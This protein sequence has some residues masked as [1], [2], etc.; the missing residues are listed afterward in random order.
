MG[1]LPVICFT[2]VY[3]FWVHGKWLS[4]LDSRSSTYRYN[5]TSSCLD[6]YLAYLTYGSFWFQL[7]GFSSNLTGSSG[8]ESSSK[9]AT[10]S[11]NRIASPHSTTL[12]PTPRR[13]RLTTVGGWC[14]STTQPFLSRLSSRRF[15]FHAFLWPQKR[16][17]GETWYF[18]PKTSN[19]HTTK[20]APLGHL[21][22]S[23][24]RST[25]TVRAHI[26]TEQT[27]TVTLSVRGHLDGRSARGLQG[28]PG[29][30]RPYVLYQAYGTKDK[31]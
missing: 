19:E 29:K 12:A 31:N 22:P 23:I 6:I 21:K 2:I 11:H 24:P 27:T 7:S 26:P 14:D 20:T 15:C 10:S 17:D 4:R 13:Q 1:K 3:K 18:G 5:L 16:M 25:R 28:L 30:G 9:T 8:L